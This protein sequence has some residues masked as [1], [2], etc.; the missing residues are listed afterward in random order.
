MYKLHLIVPISA[1]GFLDFL[2]FDNEFKLPL[3]IFIIIFFH[4]ICL[5]LFKN[6]STI[7][8]LLFSMYH[9]SR[10]FAYLNE[11]QYELSNYCMGGLVITSTLFSEKYIQWN[12][13][14]NMI[15]SSG[16][17]SRKIIIFLQ[18]LDVSFSLLLFVNV[19][20]YHRII[21]A[22]YMFLYVNMFRKSKPL[23]IIIYYLAYFHTPLNLYKIYNLHPKE[24]NLLF[25]FGLFCSCVFC[26]FINKEINF[27][28]V[29]LVMSVMV[30]HMVL[31]SL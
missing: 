20:R 15:T 16:R 3:Y 4:T 25:S 6:S 28:G 13:I 18:V 21:E 2:F 17:S 9:F 23:D 8:F 12:V 27:Q 19:F 5:Q 22:Y 29:Y 7:F 30:A 26:L 11:G 31:H 24:T 10:D 14:L 1:L